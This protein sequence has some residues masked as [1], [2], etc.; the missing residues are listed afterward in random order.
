MS[1]PAIYIIPEA[2]AAT[3]KL[4]LRRISRR[5]T[6]VMS[7]APMKRALASLTPRSVSPT[8]SIISTDDETNIPQMKR[9]RENLDHLTPAEKLARRKM[10]NREAAQSARD[11]KKSRME[12]IEQ[13]VLELQ[14]KTE[15]LEAENARLRTEN[16]TL[17]TILIQQKS[18]ASR[19]GRVSKRT[20][21]SAPCPSE[22]GIEP[23]FDDGNV[24]EVL[25]SILA[26]LRCNGSRVV[27][28]EDPEATL[29]S[30]D[31][32]VGDQSSDSNLAIDVLG[33]TQP[34]VGT[35]NDFLEGLESSPVV[36]TADPVVAM[37]D[38]G[39]IKQE[40]IPTSSSIPLPQENGIL[41]LQ[42]ENDILPTVLGNNI[43]SPD[44]SLSL[45]ESIPCITE[46]ATFDPFDLPL[47][48]EENET[49]NWLQQ[50]HDPLPMFTQ[51][52]E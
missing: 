3:P 20:P 34:H 19:T 42:D 6:P 32:I 28:K 48:E 13:A 25:E 15:K 45:M 41:S 21:R 12:M 38:H 7:V 10:K 51:S 36:F 50:M 16:E 29:P 46:D 18:S 2:A 9:R 30:V 52:V 5:D 47:D 14:N 8:S 31:E 40:E 35:Q 44:F 27:A 11:R 23:D 1:V 17:K 22:G 33:S 24:D 37:G 49:L 43:S 39:Y 26:T 4:P